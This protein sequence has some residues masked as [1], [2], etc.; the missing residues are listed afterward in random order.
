MT[1]TAELFLAQ[2]WPLREHHL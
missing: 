2:I 1:L